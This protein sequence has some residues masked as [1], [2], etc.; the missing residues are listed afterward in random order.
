MCLAIPVKVLRID[1]SLAEVELGGNI[2]AADVS[3]LEEVKVGD[4]VIMHAGI[5]IEKYDEEEAEKTLDLI[6]QIS[7]L[8]SL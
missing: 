3:L 5:A 7:E 2:M 6:R 4:Y 1:G 8:E